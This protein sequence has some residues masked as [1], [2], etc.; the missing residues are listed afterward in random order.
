VVAAQGGLDDAILD[1]ALDYHALAKP[2]G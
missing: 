1:E 2:H